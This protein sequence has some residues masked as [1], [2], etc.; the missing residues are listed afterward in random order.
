MTTAESSTRESGAN[1]CRHFGLGLLFKLNF[2]EAR[3]FTT[4][5]PR[6]IDQELDFNPKNDICIVGYVWRTSS[7]DSYIYD[8][9]NTTNLLSDP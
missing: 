5:S 2:D 6:D 4:V 8:D 1:Y 3:D 7:Y 9:V